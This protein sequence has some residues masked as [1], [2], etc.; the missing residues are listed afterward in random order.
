M[1]DQWQRKNV[2]L[3]LLS[4]NLKEFL[5][6]DHFQTEAEKTNDGHKIV[7]SG[8]KFHVVVRIRGKP[9][10]FSIEFEPGKKP[11]GF[12]SPGMIFAY[13]ATILGT[14][15]VVLKEIEIQEDV[16]KL[17]NR[18]WEHVDKQVESLTNSA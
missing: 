11:S 8:A 2:N 10:D 4:R 5:I 9:D 13:V 18:F 12:T 15:K 6:E 16:A 7:A 1:K 14:G 17:E 3:D